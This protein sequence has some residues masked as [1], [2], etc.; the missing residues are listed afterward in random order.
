MSFYTAKY[1]RE[2][3]KNIPDDEPLFGSLSIREEFEIEEYHD[4][5]KMQWSSRIPTPAE[6]VAMVDLAEKYAE[7]VW[8]AMWE[9][10]ND[11]KSDVIGGAE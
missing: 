7:P 1:I 2:L 3:L 5:D 11:A 10:M 4:D 6:W 9:C 8:E